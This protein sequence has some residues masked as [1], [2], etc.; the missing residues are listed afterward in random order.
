[1]SKGHSTIVQTGREISINELNNICQAIEGFRNPDD[2]E[3]KTQP[4]GLTC[5]QGGR[6]E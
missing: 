3:P 6:H 5:R 4:A 2:S 1:M